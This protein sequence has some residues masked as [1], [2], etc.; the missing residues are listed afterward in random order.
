VAS[1]ITYQDGRLVPDQGQFVP[2]RVLNGRYRLDEI[3]GSGTT[4][5]IWRAWDRRLDRAVAVKVL[6]GTGFGRDAGE[7]ARFHDEARTLAR[8]SHPNIVAVFDSG[9][10]NGVAYV[11]MELVEGRSAVQRLAYGVMPVAEAATVMAQVCDALAAAHAAGVVHRD[12]KPGNILFGPGRTVKVC[13]FG[14]ARLLDS[15]ALTSSHIIVGTSSYMSPEHVA[16]GPLDGRADLY[17]VGCVL[18]QMLTGTAPFVGED[19]FKIAYQQLHNHPPTVRSRRP[20]IPED[21]DG[22]VARLLAKDPAQR[23]ATAAGVRAELLRWSDPARAVA[24]AP[25]RRRRPIARVGVATMAAIAVA[26]ALLVAWPDQKAK[27]PAAAVPPTSTAMASDSP[28]PSVSPAEIVTSPAATAPFQ[29][30]QQPQQSL[31]PSPRSALDQIMGLKALVRQL[32][33]T[34]QLPPNNADELDHMLND[35]SR[36]VVEGKRP[37]AQDKFAAIQKKNDDLLAAGKI[38]PTGH[39]AIEGG[40]DP[41]AVAISGM[42]TA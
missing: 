14:I 7:R 26:A 41:L 34:G 15:T 8:L 5:T 11:V 27:P 6:D 36:L 37:E 18:F 13:D 29:L 25:A 17:S 33:A 10:E 19:P 32:D 20:D 39:L 21:L 3:V 2:S 38:S 24:T 30:V 1:H 42:P 22:L 31:S 40:L 28:A 23:P 4:A 35:L 9:T 12:I 16:G